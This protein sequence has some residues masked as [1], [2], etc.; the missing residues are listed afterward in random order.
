MFILV[1]I[2]TIYLSFI[3]VYDGFDGPPLVL[4]ENDSIF[5]CQAFNNPHMVP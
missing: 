5:I 1:F 2:Q 3:L 4:L